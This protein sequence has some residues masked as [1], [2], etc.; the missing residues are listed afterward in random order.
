[1][2]AGSRCRSYGRSLDRMRLLLAGN[3][4]ALC[5][6]LSHAKDVVEAIE[7]LKLADIQAVHELR[8]RDHFVNG[9]AVVAFEEFL[10][11]V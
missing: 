4:L 7:S 8:L 3:K 11:D 2:I 9:R 5:F 6:G 10:A 1:M